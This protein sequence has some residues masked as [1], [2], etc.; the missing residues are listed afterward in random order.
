VHLTTTRPASFVADKRT[1]PVL[2]RIHQGVHTDLRT[3]ALA[4]WEGAPR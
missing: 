2:A 4:L 1:V 3:R